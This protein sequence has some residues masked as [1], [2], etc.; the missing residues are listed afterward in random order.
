[1]TT[2]AAWSPAGDLPNIEANVEFR[3]TGLTIADGLDA[4][5]WFALV[6]RLGSL[7]A[8][9]PWWLG[10][11]LAYG[12]HKYGEKYTA[13]AKAT[14]RSEKTLRNYVY[15]ATHV[16]P[17]NRFA[18]LPWGIHRVVASLTPEEQRRWLQL[19]EE[20]DWTAE[21]LHRERSRE[22]R[23][24]PDEFDKVGVQVFGH[25]YRCPRCLH[26]WSGE[27]RPEPDAS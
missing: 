17:A 9:A 13:V 18:L 26:E 1:M 25:D 2:K 5:D 11:A 6:S 21:E 20:N 16:A 27:K 15:V 7:A 19:A 22:R 8:S 24:A 10:D 12:E 4:A 14:G 23:G 3:D